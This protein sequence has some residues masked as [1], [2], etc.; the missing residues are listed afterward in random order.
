MGLGTDVHNIELFPGKGG[1]LVRAAGTSA[2]ILAKENNYVILRLS[3]KEVRLF[4]QEM[5]RRSGMEKRT[6][7]GLKIVDIDKSQNLI[8]VK[9]SI[10]GKPGNLVS[11][12]SGI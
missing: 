6:I 3:S 1:Q 2:K 7:K 11:M 8:V 12:R 5:P 4:K 10:P 9:G